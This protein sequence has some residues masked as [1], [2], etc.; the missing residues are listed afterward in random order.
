MD[1]LLPKYIIRAHHGMCLAYFKGKGYCKDFVENMTKIKNDIKR[2]PIICIVNETED[3]CKYC[4]NNK[5]GK[6]ISYEQVL[7]YDNK[8]LEL[9]NLTPGTILQFKD[10]EKLVDEKII[11]KKIR[12]KICGN[13]QWDSLCH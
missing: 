4:P 8:V 11:S 6:C 10:F 7:Q 12:E 3:I 9:C 13:C 1:S 2:N 5:K